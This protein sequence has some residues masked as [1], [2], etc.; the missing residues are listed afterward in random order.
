MPGQPRARC[1]RLRGFQ[2]LSPMDRRF[3]GLLLG[4]AILFF[5]MACQR[6]D[7]GGVLIFEDFNGPE[8]RFF[9]YGSTGTPAPFK[10]AMGLDSPS[11]PGT[12]ILAFKLDPEDTPGAGRGPEIISRS[13]TYYG[14]YAARLK[15]PD[16]R[17]VQPDV[18]AVV[19]YFTYH[20]DSLA[21]LSEIDFEWLL[22]D[23][24]VI[25]VGTWTGH[26]G[27]LQRIGRTLN[28]AEGKI[29][30]TIHKT[31]HDG[32]PTPLAGRQ[33]QP[34]NVPAIE[35]FDA[36]AR[37]HTYGFDW[38][39]DRIRWWMLHPQSRDTVVLW[40]YRGSARGI[41]RHPSRYR[42]NFWHTDAWSVETNPRSLER[43]L[44]PYELEVDWMS[45][46]PFDTLAFRSTG[47]RQK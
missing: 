8:S 33:D 25:Y 35:G 30:H 27:A 39:P 24:R 6:K 34:A 42:M 23:P 31:N 21:G 43:P 28:L 17:D 4:T 36:S 32:V 40:D 3:N 41:P 13:F 19:G 44:H 15:V 9:H 10:W 20:M 16:V 26:P 18:G 12:R 2:Y 37:F 45:Y 46:A 11:E 29:Y 7:T 38:Y 1:F 47:S 22:A 14:R 5:L